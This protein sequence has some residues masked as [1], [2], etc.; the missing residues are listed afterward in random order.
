VNENL[1][2]FQPDNPILHNNLSALLVL[3]NK[4]M[5]RALK[6]AESA[7]FTLPTNSAIVGNYAH[8]LALTGKH[9]EALKL[10]ESIPPESYTE[11]VK[12]Q[13]AHALYLSGKTKEAA[14]FAENINPSEFLQQ[15]LEILKKIG[16]SENS[17]Q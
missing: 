1:L 4:D 10:L 9:A 17:V 8:V 7:Y 13:K 16:A 11:G 2:K 3:S 14:T 6:L 12:L 15:E 5:A